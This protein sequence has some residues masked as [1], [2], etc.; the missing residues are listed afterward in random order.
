MNPADFPAL[1][2]ITAYRAMGPDLGTAGQ[3]TEAQFTAV[4][5]AGFDAVIN[6]ALPTSTKALAN[7]GAIVTGLGMTYGHIPVDFQAPTRRDFN[8]FCGVMEAFNNSPVFVHCALNMRV[9]AFVFLHRVLRRGV[10][11]ELALPDLYAIWTPD[12]VW[13][14]FIEE[15]LAD[16]SVPAPP[17]RP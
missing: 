1:K 3:P 12:G 17:P 7:E 15:Q 8:H 6:L 13:A 10:S 4:R 9:S 2:Q 14:S 5:D 16:T 11:R